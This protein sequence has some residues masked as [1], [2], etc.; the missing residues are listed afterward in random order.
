MVQKNPNNNNVANPATNS[1]NLEEPK[2]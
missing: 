1:Q 2:K